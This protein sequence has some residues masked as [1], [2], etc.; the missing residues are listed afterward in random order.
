MDFA[1]YPL[2]RREKYIPGIWARFKLNTFYPESVTEFICFL[3][4]DLVIYDFSCKLI[5]CYGGC[6][7][8]D[9]CYL[10]NEGTINMTLYE[11]IKDMPMFEHFVEDEIKG[12]AEMEHSLQIFNKDDVIIKEGGLFTSLYLLI[13]GSLCITKTRYDTPLS[14]LKPGAV[15]GEMSFLTVK[16][17]LSNVIAIEKVLVMKMDKEFFRNAK[18]E[19]RDRIKDYLIEI[20][21]NR[22]DRMNES[23]SKI[24]NIH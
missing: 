14:T 8:D 4:H 23:L 1:L 11:L 2:F 9:L 6:A 17:R 22:L 21:V 24:S 13:K 3:F 18:P 5:R 16:P 10:D 15:F 12:F 7:T 19:I 20:L